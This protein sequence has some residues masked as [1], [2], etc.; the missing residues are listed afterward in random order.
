MKRGLFALFALA[1]FVGGALI[2]CSSPKYTAARD[3]GQTTLPTGKGAQ[4]LLFNIGW[5]P[6]TYCRCFIDND[7]IPQ[8]IRTD[9]YVEYPVPSGPGKHRVECSV[10]T[11]SV[12]VS[13]S[14]EHTFETFGTEKV[15]LSIS[16]AGI[17]GTCHISR[18]STPPDGF[19]GKYKRATQPK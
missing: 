12:P 4:M 2:G 5:V 13:F 15:Y 7:T 19:D 6:G 11:L 17:P 16:G 9:E 10:E 18:L 14:C 8:R 3:V 1:A